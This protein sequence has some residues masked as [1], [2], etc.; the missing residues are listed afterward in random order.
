[1]GNAKFPNNIWMI[2]IN[3]SLLVL[4]SHMTIFLQANEQFENI[5]KNDDYEEVKTSILKWW[6]TNN[7][8]QHLECNYKPE[9]Y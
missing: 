6:E 5:S 3:L 4:F 7:V 1:M 2:S 9:F 8:A